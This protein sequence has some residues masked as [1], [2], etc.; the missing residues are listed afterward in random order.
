MKKL[1]AV[2]FLIAM[3]T[4]AA[5]A[6]DMRL[7]QDKWKVEPGDD[8]TLTWMERSGVEPIDEFI[9]EECTD[10]QFKDTR[11]Y[12]TYPIR[13]HRKKLENSTSLTH[14][15]KYYRVKTK[16]WVRRMGENEMVKE[17]VVSNV[18]RVTLVGTTKTDPVPSFPD[19][20]DPSAPRKS[21]KG[22]KDGKSDSEYPEMGRPDLVI[23]KI[24]VDPTTPQVGK[25]YK[26]TIMVKNAGVV[27]CEAGGVRVEV[28]GRPYLLD[29]EPLKPRHS[30]AVPS[31]PLMAD[32]AGTVTVKVMLDPLGKMEESRE[33]NNQRDWTFE[34]KA[35]DAAAQ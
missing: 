20:P 19:D 18:V 17:D 14:A 16:A 29:F 35:S 26:L 24:S 7:T 8:Y 13:A 12:V 22:D 15:V 25:T 3:V 6:Q 10:P 5:S 9:L 4:G 28:N 21:K 30:V 34:V 27:P 32:A 2:L 11:N 1:L 23:T 33:D 31:T